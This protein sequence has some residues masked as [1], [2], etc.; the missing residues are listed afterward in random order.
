[1]RLLIRD[2]DDLAF[3]LAYK[4]LSED[5]QRIIRKMI[6]KIAKSENIAPISES[7]DNGAIAK[8]QQK[9]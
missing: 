2:E 9:G 4:K 6:F 7:L 1:M 5:K 3:Y 8:K